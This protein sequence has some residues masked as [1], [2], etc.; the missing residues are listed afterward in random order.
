MTLRLRIES[1]GLGL[2]IIS[3]LKYWKLKW[4]RLDW[5]EEIQW[6]V[7]RFDFHI[8]I[9]L[10]G[11]DLCTKFKS[12]FSLLKNLTSRFFFL[13]RI[14]VRISLFLH[15]R[16]WDKSYLLVLAYL[17]KPWFQSLSFFSRG[18]FLNRESGAKEHELRSFNPLT[19]KIS[20]EILLTLF[21]AFLP[22]TI[23]EYGIKSNYTPESYHSYAYH[24]LL[25]L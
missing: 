3:Q 19:F 21:H 9:A 23:W 5:V 2:S 24:W 12:R 7:Y 6:R 17:E 8:C 13:N 14:F 15:S 11:Q 18:N 25:I 4:W 1:N 22:L 10:P 16:V 20:R